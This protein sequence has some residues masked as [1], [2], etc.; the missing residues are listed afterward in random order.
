MNRKP[1]DFAELRKVWH[2]IEEGK[3]NGEIA[4]ALG[5]EPGTIKQIRARRHY[6]TESAII[7]KEMRRKKEN[8]NGE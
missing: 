5:R 1:F 8:G 2:M 6:T 3:T 4:Q 7:I